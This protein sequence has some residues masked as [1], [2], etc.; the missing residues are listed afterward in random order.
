MEIHNFEMQ[1][2]SAKKIV[3]ESKYSDRNKELILKFVDDLAL[4]NL[5]KPRLSKYLCIMNQITRRLGIDLDKA[6]KDDVKKLV[7]QIQ[8]NEKYS[9]WTKKSYKIVIR[10]FYKWLYKTKGCPEIVDFITIGIK[11]SER[12]LPSDEDLLTEGDIQK[13]IAAAN[14]PRDKA[15]IAALWESG[16]RVGELGNLKIK[17]AGFDQYGI[18][19]IMKGKTGSRK[20]RLV[21]STPYFSTWLNIHPFAND[22]EA[23]LWVNIGPKSNTKPLRYGAIRESFRRFA[24]KAGIHKR[25]NPHTFRHSRATFM[26]NHLTEF[27]MNQY[28]GWIQGSDMPSTYVHMSGKEVDNA[29]LAM[30]GIKAPDNKNESR[31]QPRICPRC[32]TIN[33][34]EAKHCNKCAGILDLK[35]AMELEETQAQELKIRTGSDQL[36]NL[37]LKDKEVQQLLMEKI[38]QLGSLPL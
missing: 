27:Q 26:A 8:Q 5:S 6:S 1:F 4:E 19:L 18:T 10:R 33:S 11:R 24:V 34:P 36:M 2:Q 7:S 30:N 38:K 22:K 32:D 9:P 12:K 31:L 23:P 17:N 37:L 20:V 21:F 15:F 13:L 28:F 14:H 35:Y 16:A 25:V 29:I 3:S